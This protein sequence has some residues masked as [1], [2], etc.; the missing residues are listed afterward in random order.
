[1]MSPIA[2]AAAK[3][4]I[5]AAAIV[6]VL[7]RTRSLPRA[8]LG[9]VRPP[10]YP[11]VLILALYLAWMFGT[12]AAIHWRGPWDFRPWLAAPLLASILRVVAVGLLGPIA[13]ELIF[14]GWF[15]GAIGKRAG[16]LI[17]ILVTS[18]G[19]TMLHYD[20]G[21]AVLG[22]I[23]VDGLLLGLARWR[24][25]SVYPPIVMHILYNLYAIW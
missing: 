5:A 4:G 22:I 9:L 24:T 21:L 2:S 6:L 14:R 15:L 12:D 13:E 1:M 20:Y 7:A 10:L 25:E 17:A 18:A 23:F 8:E 3:A 16:S 11:S 19:W